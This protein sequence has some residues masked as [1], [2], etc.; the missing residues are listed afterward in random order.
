MWFHPR[1]QT[2][3]GIHSKDKNT[4]KGNVDAELVLHAMIQF[5]KYD[6]CI[7]VSG[8]GDFLC[9]IEHLHVNQKLFKI[10]APNKK[11]SSL[12]RDYASSIVLIDLLRGKLEKK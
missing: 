10:L 8:D 6:K 4:Y 9:L 2:G 5:P 3:P 7:I 11:Y 1:F 12:L